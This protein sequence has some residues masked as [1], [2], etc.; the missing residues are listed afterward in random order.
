[1][2]EILLAGTK[3][4]LGIS[5]ELDTARRQMA[6]AAISNSAD[7]M[8]AGLAAYSSAAAKMAASKC[9]LS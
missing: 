6:N 1:M 2:D 9:S 3:A 4:G 8:K 5:S 7:D